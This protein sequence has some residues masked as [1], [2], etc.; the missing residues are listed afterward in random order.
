M[1]KKRKSISIDESLARKIDQRHEINFSSLVNDLVKHYFAGDATSHQTKT[2]LEVQLQHVQDEIEQ[3]EER[4]R[5]LRKR[6]EELK[7]LIEEHE[8]Q[9]DPLVEKALEVLQDLPDD[10]LHAENDAVINWASKIEI[11][12]AKLVELVKNERD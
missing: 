3:K 12:P 8:D 2:A 6:E 9:Q 1:G 7:Q 10:K 11:S 4:L 5:Q